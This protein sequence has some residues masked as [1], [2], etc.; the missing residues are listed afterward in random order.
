M[1]RAG[2]ALH[3][4]ATT[5]SSAMNGRVKKIHLYDCAS[6]RHIAQLP[7]YGWRPNPDSASLRRDIA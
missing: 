5:R 7:L 1:S 4:F 3:F 2:R 6:A